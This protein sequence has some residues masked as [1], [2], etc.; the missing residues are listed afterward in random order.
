MVSESVTLPASV[1]MGALKPFLRSMRTAS[2][3]SMSGKSIS[4][5][6]RSIC[7][8]L[9][10]C[11][12]LVQLPL[13]TPRVAKSDPSAVDQAVSKIVQIGR[14]RA[15]CAASTRSYDRKLTVATN[16]RMRIRANRS[17]TTGSGPACR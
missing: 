5:I 3:P 6:T 13:Q 1:M 2:R 7:P 12:P 15:E 10:T 11:T 4:M 9:A 17:A 16:D 14:K 8:S